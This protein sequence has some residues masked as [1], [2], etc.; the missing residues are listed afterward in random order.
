MRILPDLPDLR[1]LP[2]DS[3]RPHE[4]DDAQRGGRLQAALAREGVLRN[5]PI[6]LQLTAHPERYVVLDGANRTAAFREMGIRYI[7]AQ[8]VHAGDSRVEIETWNHAVLG[9]TP[10]ALE[11]ALRSLEGVELRPAEVGEAETDLARRESLAYLSQRGDRTLSIL[12]QVSD[13]ARRVE[14]LNRLVDCYRYAGTVERTNARAQREVDDA[15]AQLA[16]LL[17]FLPFNVQD[18]VDAVSEGWLLPGGLTRFVVSPRALRVNYPIAALQS[19]EPRETKERA[20]DEWLKEQVARRRV[21]YY[22][23][24]TYLFD[25]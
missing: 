24:A 7:L 4:H 8:V 15:F 13:A 23:E 3:L 25:E 2:V 6:V 5:P 12:A 18:V 9:M 16:G 17:V 20:L 14:G 21:R 22:A 10:E 1:V 11:G 19:D